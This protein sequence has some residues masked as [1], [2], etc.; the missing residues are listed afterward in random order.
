MRAQT[1]DNSG[2]PVGQLVSLEGYDPALSVSHA[3]TVLVYR[4]VIDDDGIPEDVLPTLDDVPALF[5]VTIGTNGS[6]LGTTELMRGV[7]YPDRSTDS[8]FETTAVASLGTGHVIAWKSYENH[9]FDP[10]SQTGTFDIIHYVQAFTGFGPVSQP[11]EVG[12]TVVDIAATGNGNFVV[13]GTASTAETD[14]QDIVAQIFNGT[15]GQ[16]VSQPFVVNTTTDGQQHVPSVTSLTDGAG[17]FIVVWHDEPNDAVGAQAYNALGVAQGDQMVVTLEAAGAF[18]WDFSSPDIAADPYGGFMVTWTGWDESGWGVRGQ[19]YTPALAVSGLFGTGDDDVDF[20]ELTA[21]QQD[22]VNGAAS[23]GQVGAIYDAQA[24]NDTIRLP[25]LVEAQLTP[26]VSWDYARAFNAGDGNDVVHGGDGNDVLEGGA[27]DDALHGDAG[28]DTLRGGAG[29]DQ[30]Y[31]G[32]G[33]DL[34]SKF[35]GDVGPFGNDLYDGGSGN[36]RVSYYLDYGPGVTVDLNLTTAQ[37]TGY[38]NDTFVSIEHIT[39]SYGDDT[40]VGNAAANWF[41]TFNGSD[42]LFG[43]GGNDYFTVGLGNKIVDGGDG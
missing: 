18:E 21:G 9:T 28:N 38:G 22:S 42:N 39:A 15:S 5:A 23:A 41:W 14:A 8:Y 24:G 2:Y 27:G 13:I 16:P 43:N 36:D 17:G 20:G 31:G 30:L 32:A 25:D 10:V 6:I 3:G 7:V 40:L 4:T 19:T 26:S 34:L 1:Y 35:A 33:N 12:F 37:A 29:S 11:F